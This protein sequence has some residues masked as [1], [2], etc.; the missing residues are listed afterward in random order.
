MITCEYF[1]DLSSYC[2]SIGSISI[3]VS[4]ANEL[5]SGLSSDPISI[6]KS[7]LDNNCHFKGK[8]TCMRW[9]P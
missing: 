4:A 2:H 9:N 6:G 7:V 1:P 3:I 5:G 8:V